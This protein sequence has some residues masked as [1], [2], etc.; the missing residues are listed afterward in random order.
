MVPYA[1][2]LLTLLI[3]IAPAYKT[4]PVVVKPKAKPSVKKAKKSKKRR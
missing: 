2:A 3:S 1:A 4:Q